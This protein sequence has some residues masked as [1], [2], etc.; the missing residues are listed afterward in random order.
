[1]PESIMTILKENDRVAWLQSFHP[2]NEIERD[3]LCKLGTGCNQE[4]LH[5]ETPEL[6]NTEHT[7]EHLKSIINSEFEESLAQPKVKS[8]I[9]QLLGSR[10]KT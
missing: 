1:M 7:V 2:S 10:W 4:N 8:R 6:K 3:I 5:L 9:S